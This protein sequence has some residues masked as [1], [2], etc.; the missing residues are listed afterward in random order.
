MKQVKSKHKDI[1]AQSIMVC[2]NCHKENIVNWIVEGN[3][4]PFAGMNCKYCDSQNLEH[5]YGK[6]KS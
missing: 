5:K 6:E 2:N 4:Y 3:L 1:N